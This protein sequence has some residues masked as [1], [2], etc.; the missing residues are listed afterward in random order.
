MIYD[1]HIDRYAYK[2]HSFLRESR[3]PNATAIVYSHREYSHR[4]YS[5]GNTISLG[6]EKHMKREPDHRINASE[7]DVGAMLPFFVTAINAG[8]AAM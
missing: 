7:C 2:A 8:T 5:H 1:H 6:L 3:I 4:E